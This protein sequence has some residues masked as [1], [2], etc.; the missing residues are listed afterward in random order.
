MNLL[1]EK[2]MIMR[3]KASEMFRICIEI[4]DYI[5]KTAGNIELR[6]T[7]VAEKIGKFFKL[8]VNGHFVDTF[9]AES[10]VNKQDC[11]EKMNH[12]VE[13]DNLERSEKQCILIASS[14]PETVTFKKNLLSKGLDPERLKFPKKSKAMV[15]PIDQCLYL[16]MQSMTN[17][18]KTSTTLFINVCSFTTIM[19]YMNENFESCIEAIDQCSKSEFCGF[20]ITNACP[21]M[22]QIIND[23]MDQTDE[24]TEKKLEYPVECEKAYTNLM[25]RDPLNI[26]QKE[27]GGWK[28]FIISCYNSPTYISLG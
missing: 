21:S 1:S 12:C 13:I 9:I 16:L 18:D 2:E 19:N 5:I 20:N 11:L 26:N 28:M 14:C 6:L 22:E 10:L 7:D 27:L 15:K 3:L 24:L 4:Y 25:E 8:C 17:L 23:F